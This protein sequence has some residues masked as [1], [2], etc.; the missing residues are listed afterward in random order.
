MDSGEAGG[1]SRQALT[2][3]LI[4]CWDFDVFANYLT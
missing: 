4:S 2:I 1:E 3:A